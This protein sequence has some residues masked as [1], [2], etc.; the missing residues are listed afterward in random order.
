MNKNNKSSKTDSELN[1]TIKE[2]NLEL[3]NENLEQTEQNEQSNPIAKLL[4]EAYL[5][6]E[7]ANEENKNGMLCLKKIQKIILKPSIKKN[8]SRKNLL[9]SSKEKK[10]SGISESTII[11][12]EL[13]NLLNL[14]EI[15]MPRTVLTKKVYEY[16]GQNNLKYSEN[17]RIM[18]VNK[19]LATA[20]R[21]TPEQIEKINKSNDEKDKDGLNF[22]NL[23]IWISKLYDKNNKDN[24]DN[25][26]LLK[27]K[28][29]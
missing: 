14:Q 5:H 29:I 13:K 19:Q 4:E 7:K 11:P 17:K 28:S 23:Q 21:L 2:K 8:K 26:D 3:V 18:R 12:Q 15:N 24:K 1:I 10:P 22:Y 20:L 25:K 27:S 6:F 16:I 9:S